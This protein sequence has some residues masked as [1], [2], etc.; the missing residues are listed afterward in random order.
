MNRLLALAL[1]LPSL[2]VAATNYWICPTNGGL[3][4]SSG[5]W[6]GGTPATNDIVFFGTANGS[7]TSC[8]VDALN[9]VALVVTNSYTATIT[10]ASNILLTT[11]GNAGAFACN[12][13]TGDLQ[14]S[15]ATVEVVNGNLYFTSLGTNN[16]AT[17][18][19]T[20]Q[21]MSATLGGVGPLVWQVGKPSTVFSLLAG[22]IQSNGQ[23]V[24]NGGTIGF[25]NNW[26]WTSYHPNAFT[27]KVASVCSFGVTTYWRP[28]APTNY[29]S[30]LITLSGPGGGY[31][32][33]VAPPTNCLVQCYGGNQTFG[34]VFVKSGAG[35]FS[36]E[37]QRVNYASGLNHYDGIIY[38]TNSQLSVAGA[39][40]M[41]NQMIADNGTLKFGQPGV[42]GDL[43]LF[44]T[45]IVTGTN[46]TFLIGRHTGYIT[47]QNNQYLQRLRWDAGAGNNGTYI[48]QATKVADLIFD[49]NLQH[50][51]TQ[52]YTVTV[53][54][55]TFSS[56]SF[57]CGAGTVVCQG[58]LL[59]KGG[60]VVGGSYTMMLT[61]TG[62]HGWT[63]YSHLAITGP[64]A[65]LTNATVAGRFVAAGAASNRI[66]ASVTG[67]LNIQSNAQSYVAFT[68]WTGGSVS[69]KPVIGYSVWSSNSAT[70]IRNV[71]RA[72]MGGL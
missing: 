40:T 1:L 13:R 64:S 72:T 32:F 26:D 31:Q 11:N 37:S 52:G 61:G 45:S 46:V 33:A 5:N 2:A 15:N 59:G 47:I 67:V 18:V 6:S 16:T 38:L 4:S 29:L 55:L 7:N 22:G 66:V 51:L 57:N 49:Q 14:G 43:N 21:A 50:L 41:Q 34:D 68:D 60:P 27:A 70:G 30:H 10:L 8:I 56:G 58:S 65:S 39:L 62:S 12:Q 3:A 35:V 53:T 54:N 36:F 71:R 44:S 42:R 48:Q 24:L 17:L 20:Q 23:F 25:Y 19:T 63:N 28:S 9:P 69:N